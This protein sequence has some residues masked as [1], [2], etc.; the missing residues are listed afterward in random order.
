MLWDGLRGK[1]RDSGWD[2]G[3][4]EGLW[5]EIWGIWRGRGRL[6]EQGVEGGLGDLGGW[7][8]GA[9]G[10]EGGCDL[11]RQRASVLKGR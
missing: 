2:L 4:S 7:R 1:L 10:A 9:W 6:R 8:E 3:L 11:M 5:A